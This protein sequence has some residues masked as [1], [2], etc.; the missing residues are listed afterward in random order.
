[1]TT[2]QKSIEVNV[3]VQTA[4]NQWTQFEEFPQ[5]MDGIKE[6]Q[7]VDDGRLRWVAEVG[8][9]RKE[10]FAR[11][12]RQV[13]DQVVAWESESGAP[14]SG[15]V[16]FHAD[17]DDKTEI[18]VHI[19]YEPADIKEE[20]GSALGIASRRV[21]GDLKRFKEFIESRGKESGAWRGEIS[22]GMTEQETQRYGATG[23]G[24][25]GYG[26]TTPGSVYPGTPGALGRPQ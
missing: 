20:A 25:T 10:W 21:E 5:F 2:V 26:G 4:Y 12:T 8:G 24:G 6:V 23:Q 18:E 9:E 11:I 19:D 15:L 17:G 3:P 14:N 7:Q 16:S 1:M 22:G 13:P